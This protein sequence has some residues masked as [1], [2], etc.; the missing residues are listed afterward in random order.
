WRSAVPKAC[1]RSRA[2]SREATGTEAWYRPSTSAACRGW[3][4]ARRSRQ[5]P[6]RRETR[7][8]VVMGGNN[9]RSQADCASGWVQTNQGV[10]VLSSP[11]T[12]TIAGDLDATCPRYDIAP[13]RAAGRLDP[14]HDQ[15]A[16]GAASGRIQGRVPR[17]TWQ[18][19]C[20][21]L[22]QPAL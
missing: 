18:L 17:A 22:A 1:C 9:T 11:R 10:N 13:A 6:I 15:P 4:S 20:L 16:G 19:A 21:I 5:K 12:A 2:S 3:P 8:P 7:K 14:G